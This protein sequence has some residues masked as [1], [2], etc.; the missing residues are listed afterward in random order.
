MAIETLDD[1]AEELADKF[2]IY[3]NRNAWIIELK[4][5]II[6]AIE[7]ERAVHKNYGKNIDAIREASFERADLESRR[8]DK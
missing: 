3:E 8:L 2:G 1:I 4:A 7:T 6:T 5:R